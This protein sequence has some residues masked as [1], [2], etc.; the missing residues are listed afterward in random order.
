MYEDQ[1]DGPIRVSLHTTLTCAAAAPDTR[2]PHEAGTNPK[3]R[4]AVTLSPGSH[5]A[6]PEKN[7]KAASRGREARNKETEESGIV[8]IQANSIEKEDERSDGES[9]I[10]GEVCGD[11][12]YGCVSS[13]D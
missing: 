1:C 2:E 9:D 5:N 8:G 3:P 4:P 7:E 6:G 12:V 13:E 10:R 11:I